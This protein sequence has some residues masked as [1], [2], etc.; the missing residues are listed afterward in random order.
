MTRAHISEK[1]EHEEIV[2]FIRSYHESIVTA[3]NA[4]VSD[5]IAIM[6]LQI[7]AYGIDATVFVGHQDTYHALT[8]HDHQ[9]RQTT[10]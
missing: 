2:P 10:I 9:G 4:Y 1:H 5:G 3:V 7:R 6:S 8:L